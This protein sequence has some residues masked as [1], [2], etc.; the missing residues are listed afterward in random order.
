MH[1]ACYCHTNKYTIPPFYRHKLE[2]KISTLKLHVSDE[3]LQWLAEFFRH[4]P[5][6][7]S[8]SMMGL[9]DSIDGFIEPN[10]PAVVI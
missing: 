8:N 6:P 10:L 4:V 5:V 3:K 1:W 2:A 9:D 7:R